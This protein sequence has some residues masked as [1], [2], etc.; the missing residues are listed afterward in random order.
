MVNKCLFYILVPLCGYGQSKVRVLDQNNV[1][2][3]YADILVEKSI[4]T[5]SD[6][7]GYFISGQIGPEQQYIITALGFEESL[8]SGDV[9]QVV[10]TP[11]ANALDEVVVFK[12]K[13]SHT[14]KYGKATKRGRAVA[15]NFDAGNSQFLKYVPN[16]STIADPLF[17]KAISFYTKASSKNRKISIVFLSIGRDGKPSQII[18]DQN[19]IYRLKEGTHLNNINVSRLQ[20]QLPAEGLF[21]G[22][23]HLLID[24][25]KYYAPSTAKKRVKQL[26]L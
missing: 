2:V 8:I 17:I 15:V 10:L 16:K 6:S 14:E 23:Q 9:T 21:I 25:N 22:I 5:T 1:P 11:K 19:F 4:V 24:D 13:Y 20:I 7:L 12:P 26:L 18:N 3:P